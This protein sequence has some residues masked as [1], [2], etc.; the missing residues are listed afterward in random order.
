MSSSTLFA[1]SKKIKMM[2]RK[3]KSKYNSI[4]WL[5]EGKWLTLVNSWVRRE[6]L[7]SPIGR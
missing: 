4:S 2:I 5:N 7:H 3:A 6:K 1:V